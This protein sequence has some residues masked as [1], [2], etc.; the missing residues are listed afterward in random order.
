MGNAVVDFGLDDSVERLFMATEDYN[1]VVR[2]LAGER[3]TT[4]QGYPPDFHDTSFIRRVE[5]E[6]LPACHDRLWYEPR[7][8]TQERIIREKILKK[9]MEV[10]VTP[11][12][13][14][15][16]CPLVAGY[17]YAAFA[18]RVFSHGTEPIAISWSIS[19]SQSVTRPIASSP[20]NPEAC[21]TIHTNTLYYPHDLQLPFSRLLL[22]H[23]KRRCRHTPSYSEQSAHQ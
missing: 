21:P 7:T 12:S 15:T 17:V 3:P 13:L 5:T 14:F 23:G 4:E 2:L 8:L 10:E 22:Y 16:R 11:A 19:V 18:K 9:H 20:F 1:P 6:N